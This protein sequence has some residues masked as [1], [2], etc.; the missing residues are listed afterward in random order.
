[1]TEGRVAPK[2][3]KVKSAFD[4]LFADG[5][6]LGACFALCMDG[7]IVAD[8]W[9]GHTDKAH[10]KTWQRDT[11]VNVWSC[12][13]GI[14]AVAIAMEV[15]RGRLNYDRPVAEVWPEFAANGKNHI[16]LG[17]LLSHQGGLNGLSVP[18]DEAG[19][20]AWTPYVD[21]LAAMAPLWEPGSRCVYH[22]LSYGHLAGEPLRRVSGHRV[23]HYVSE[24]IA[25]PLDVPF[26]IGLPQSEDHRVAEIIEGPKASDWVEQVLQSA[27]PHACMNPRPVASAPNTR[28]WRAAEIPGG[29]GHTDARAMASIYGSLVDGRS[30]L[31]SKAAVEAATQVRFSGIDLAFQSETC[32]GAGFRMADPA[33][34]HRASP[35]AFGHSGWGGAIGFADPEAKLG[36]AYVTNYLLGFDDGID[37]RRQRM[38]DAVYDAL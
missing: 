28:A 4:S 24:N 5:L 20:Y 34:A 10:R 36:F 23:G 2:F 18:M 13:K 27:Y 21:A 7:K 11:L 3:A 35:R 25:R 17:Q 37:P 29:N 19:L 8:L 32:F 31:L 15:E 16:T 14:M 22:A 6:E 30:R 1:M 12:T 26:H 9:G 33:Y 38:I